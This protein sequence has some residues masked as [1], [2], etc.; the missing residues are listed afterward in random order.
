[1][2]NFAI[3]VG[4]WHGAWAWLWYADVM[5]ESDDVPYMS[6]NALSRRGATRKAK[7]YIRRLTSPIENKS[8]KVYVYDESTFSLEEID[9]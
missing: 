8:A 9:V 2:R 3:I 5:H 6:F 7:R 4:R 1:M